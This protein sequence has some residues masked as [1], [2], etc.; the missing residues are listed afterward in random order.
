MSAAAG[1]IF[2][3]DADGPPA[4]D[5]ALV[6][7]DTTADTL[8]NIDLGS[9]QAYVDAEA[10]SRLWWRFPGGMGGQGDGVAGVV[11]NGMKWVGRLSGCAAHIITGSQLGRR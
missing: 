2:S 3:S 7:A 6:L 4:F 11:L 10:L 5:R 9:L 1:L 8:L